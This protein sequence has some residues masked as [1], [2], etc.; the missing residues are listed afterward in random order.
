M[1][2]PRISLV[3]P[4]YNEAVLLP[5]LLETVARARARHSRGADAI[6]IVVADNASTDDTAR[7]ARDAGCRV[8]HVEK[9]SIAAARNGGARA[10]RGG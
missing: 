6:E 7:I 8:V 10:A 3:V 5:A 2:A 4:A 9:R 1:A